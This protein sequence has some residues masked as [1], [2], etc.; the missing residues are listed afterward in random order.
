MTW[1]YAE[2]LKVVMPEVVLA[3][4]M[5]VVLAV[6]LL[7]MRET[8]RRYRRRVAAALSAVGCVVAALTLTVGQGSTAAGSMVVVDGLTVILQAALLALAALVAG[9]SVDEDLGDHVGEGFALLLLATLGMLLLVATEHLLM[10]FVALEIVSLSLYVLVGWRKPDPRSAEAALKYFLF[11]SVASAFALYGF[12]LLYGAT[13]SVTLRGVAVALAGQ[14]L[15]PWMAGALVM[16]LM[17]LGFKVAAVPFHLWAPETYQG[18]PTTSAAF[19]ASSSKVAGFAVLAKVVLLG[20]PS[21][22]G[23][24]AWHGWVGGWAPL[25]A[26]LALFSMVL[27]NLGAL[28]QVSVK[29]LLAYSAVAHAGYTLVG[30]ASGTAAGSVAV[31]YYAVTYAAAVLGAF[32]VL[33][34]VRESESDPRLEHLA[35]L[36][37]QAPLMALCLLLFLLSLA[38]IPPLAGFFG[39]FALFVAAVQPGAGHGLLW[40][41]GV[42]V[43]MSAVSLYYYLMILKQAYIAPVPEQPR[44]RSPGI[45]LQI[46]VVL[47]AGVVLLLGCFPQWLVG[48]LSTGLRSAGW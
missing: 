32:G 16:I 5:L 48:P 37:R 19:I 35:G 12:S 13:D 25:L 4:V 6:D 43:A 23:S 18:A 27:G 45:T 44:L 28:A 26:V 9:I 20:L 22:T 38:G 31:L 2:V 17:G 24:G 11:G 47:L 36:S 42:A 29:R 3:A 39:K 30:L 8:D 41:V 46:C 15:T 34:L 21:A 14:P 40:L 1:G 7:V 33:S 10:I